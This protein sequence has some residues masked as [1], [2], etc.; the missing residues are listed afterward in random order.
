[1]E[2]MLPPA[3]QGDPAENGSHLANADGDSDSFCS[4]SD[5]TPERFVSRFIAKRTTAKWRLSGIVSGALT[6]TARTAGS[7]LGSPFGEQKWV[8]PSCR[9]RHESNSRHLAGM[10]LTDPKIAPRE[11]LTSG[12][13]SRVAT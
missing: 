9:M 3:S 2:I 1:M 4:G 8:F 13:R 5:G 6:A 7:P 12:M 11:H 10:V